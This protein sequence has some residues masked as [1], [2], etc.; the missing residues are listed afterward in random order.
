[1]VH[2]QTPY[3]LKTNDLENATPHV[4]EDSINYR[5]KIALTFTAFLLIFWGIILF[6]INHP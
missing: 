6:I 1:M 2:E 5:R 3:T 4:A